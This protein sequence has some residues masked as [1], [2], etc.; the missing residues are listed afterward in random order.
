MLSAVAAI[1]FLIGVH[2]FLS[3]YNAVRVNQKRLDILTSQV[4]LLRRNE[5]E[6]VR[7]KRVMEKVNSFLTKARGSGIE[8][9]RWTFHTVNINEGMTFPD[10]AKILKQAANSASYYFKP[11]TLYIKKNKGA[12]GNSKLSPPTLVKGK[13]A[14]KGGDLSLTLRGSFVVKEK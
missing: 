4:R 12:A 1:S 10:A 3:S 9:D 14:P 2:F 8:R 13:A 5:R 6:L 7:K 11:T